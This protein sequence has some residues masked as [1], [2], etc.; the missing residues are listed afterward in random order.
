MKRLALLLGVTACVDDPGPEVAFETS[1]IASPD[2]GVGRGACSQTDVSDANFDRFRTALFNDLLPRARTVAN[3]PAFRQCVRNV[4][5]NGNVQLALN[6]WQHVPNG[7][8]Q[9]FG[10]YIPFAGDRGSFATAGL[11]LDRMRDIQAMRV[12]LEATSPHGLRIY[13]QKESG[14][15][16]NGPSPV[17]DMA[18][19]EDMAISK[20]FFNEDPGPTGTPT[21]R[22]FR[23]FTA[24]VIWHELM[25]ERNYWHSGQSP[26]EPEY[27]N[28]MP[29]IVGACMDESFNRAERNCGLSS[30]SGGFNAL[31]DFNG[32]PGSCACVRDPG[33]GFTPTLVD[34]WSWKGLQKVGLDASGQAYAL[35]GL[36]GSTA[37]FKRDGHSWTQVAPALDMVA[38]GDGVSI[39]QPN[40]VLYQPPRWWTIPHVSGWT[41]TDSV[42]GE[43]MSMDSFGRLVRVVNG[44]VERKRGTTPWVNLGPASAVAAG[45]DLLYKLS[46]GIASRLDDGPTPTWTSLGSLDGSITVDAYGTLFNLASNQSLWRHRGTWWEQIGGPNDQIGADAS[47]FTHSPV[48]GWVYRRAPD[49]GWYRVAQCTS[50]AVGGRSLLCR[51]GVTLE[52]YEY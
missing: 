13:C 20:D 12:V 34:S 41:A 50:F 15:W 31:L 6:R 10:P 37:L 46:G 42:P 35:A 45:S 40:P 28:R 38:G 49:N 26:N 43:T 16:A 22:G 44:Q 21:N 14:G 39:K 51:R 2:V 33:T 48:D 47:F 27:N 36:T 19:A 25:H 9:R 11:P 7:D 4:I 24:A 29:A 23:S 18:V 5:T 1:E 8:V 3:S 52:L 32:D 30:C 17:R